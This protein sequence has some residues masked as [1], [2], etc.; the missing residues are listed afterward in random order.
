MAFHSGMLGFYAFCLHQRILS[1]YMASLG[2]SDYCARGYDALNTL[3]KA[4]DLDLSRILLIV[5]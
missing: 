2:I 5:A 4:L 1:A 3:P